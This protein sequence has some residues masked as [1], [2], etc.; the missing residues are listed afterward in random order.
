I[1]NLVGGST[2]AIS[3]LTINGGAINSGTV[4]AGAFS[5]LSVAGGNTYAQTAGTTTV[6]GA[7][8]AAA[9][10]VTGGVL[11]FTSAVTAASGTG[12]ITLGG[13]GAVE[14]DAAVA[15]GQTV[16]FASAAG[17]VE[18]GAPGQFSG[19]IGGFVVGDTID[20]LKT[21]VTNLAYSNGVLTVKNGGAT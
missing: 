2:S 12:P 19:T 20:L 5:T 13:N 6:A 11:D 1:V 7:L 4:N 3:R 18:L 14:F 15:A 17:T 10:N 9:I 16:T 8:S 21:A